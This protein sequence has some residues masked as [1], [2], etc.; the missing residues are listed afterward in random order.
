MN[1]ENFCI[2]KTVGKCFPFLCLTLALSGP[3]FGQIGSNAD[4][5]LPVP[6]A[7]ANRIFH[8]FPDPGTVEPG[9]LAKPLSAQEK[10]RLF[11]T[12]TFDPHSILLV[13]TVA[14]IQQAGNL[15]PVYGH[16][17]GPYGQRVGASAAVYTT[18]L[19]FTQAVLPALTRQD[20]R[21]YRKG[22]GKVVP[23]VWYALSRMVV[24]RSDSGKE[25]FNVSQL[26]GLAISTAISNAYIPATERNASEN[27][28]GFGI[29][30]A[31]SAGINILREFGSRPPK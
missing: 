29:G 23:R 28:A 4:A 24:T 3:A 31:F 12:Q 27:A 1:S 30:V 6:D 16:G 7:P 18:S 15:P 11:A 9:Q 17:I 5:L 14:G 8:A 20:P 26:G 19:L 21:Y 22:S 10:F 13:A 25:E 2:T